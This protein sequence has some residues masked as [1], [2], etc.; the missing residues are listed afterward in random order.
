[1]V[2]GA[3]PPEDVCRERMGKAAVRPF[4][5]IERPAM[6]QRIIERSARRDEGQN[7]KRG[8]P[9]RQPGDLC[10]PDRGPFSGRRAG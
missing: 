3:A 6:V 10:W 5:G 7:I 8:A 1:M 4:K 9:C 2:D